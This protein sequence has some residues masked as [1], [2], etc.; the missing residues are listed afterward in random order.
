M[1]CGGIQA[2]DLLPT[3]FAVFR[4][5]T[6]VAYDGNEWYST[7]VLLHFSGRFEFQCGYYVRARWTSSHITYALSS[8]NGFVLSIGLQIYDDFHVLE[9]WAKILHY[10]VGRTQLLN[11]WRAQINDLWFW[12]PITKRM[13]D[14]LM[15]A[16]VLLSL[17]KSQVVLFVSL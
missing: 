4:R 14:R 7:W 2:T 10:K 12:L 13:F 5:P 15:G 16:I 11:N 1:M 9:S 3:D 6:M 17:F 8:G